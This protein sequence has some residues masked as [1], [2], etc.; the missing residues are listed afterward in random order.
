MP[1]PGE[2]A[3]VPEIRASVPEDLDAIA[4]LDVDLFGLDSWSRATH[5]DELASP[6]RRY[7]SV[8][9]GSTLVGWGGIIVAPVSDLL[10]IGVARTH[11]RRGIGAAL[12]A[13]LLAEAV[14]V[15][16]EEMFLEVRADDAGA[17]RLYERAGF[18]AIATRP[19]YYQ[20]SGADAV[21]MQRSLGTAQ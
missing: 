1:P 20:A 13:A 10:T 9:D 19:N 21:V 14:A 18:A 2:N 17:Q 15:G 11:Q 12:L 6:F 5:R 4:A 8:V 16:V 7:L 3:P